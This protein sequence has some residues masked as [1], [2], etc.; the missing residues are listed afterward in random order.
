MITQNIH[1]VVSFEVIPTSNPNG[2]GDS[3]GWIT[4]RAFSRSEW[5]EDKAVFEFTFFCHNLTEA[6]AQ[7]Q[8]QTE[9]QGL[10]YATAD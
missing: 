2:A 3:D 9:I 8:Q 6:L 7:L 1:N 4:L 5:T 10:D